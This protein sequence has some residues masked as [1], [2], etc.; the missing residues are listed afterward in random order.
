[1]VTANK[2]LIADSGPQLV[3]LAR[4]M[5]Q[6]LEF[7]ASVAGGIPAI[8]AIQEGL[9]GDRLHRIAGILNGTCNY[10]LREDGSGGLKPKWRLKRSLGFAEA[11]P[12]DDI[13]DSGV[14][15]PAGDLT[16]AVCAAAGK[17]LRK[18][19]ARRF[20]RLRPVVFSGLLV[21]WAA[22]FARSP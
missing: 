6:R 22:L 5:G 7:G 17:G 9:A 3:E 15:V 2:L 1:M 13:E 18:F 11:D 4:Q 19:L 14:P 12:R 8:I 16:Q 21:N 10:I 20:L